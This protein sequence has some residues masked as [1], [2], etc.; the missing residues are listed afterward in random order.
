VSLFNIDPSNPTNLTLAGNP[1]DSLGDY[2]ISVALL[3]PNSAISQASLLCV[4]NTGARSNLVCFT[5]KSGEVVGHDIVLNLQLDTATPPVS[6]DYTASNVFFAGTYELLTVFRGSPKANSIG[7]IARCLVGGITQCSLTSI[8]GSS[9]PSGGA[10]APSTD[11]FYPK[12]VITDPSFGAFSWAI[13]PANMTNAT[14]SKPTAFYNTIG[15]EGTQWITHST[16]TEEFYMTSS[17]DNLAKINSYGMVESMFIAGG[18]LT[19]LAAAGDWVF[20]LDTSRNICSVNITDG[21]SKFYGN[22]SLPV[23]SQGLAVYSI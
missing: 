12:V 20:I 10:S 7:S 15:Y 1:I 9:N 21:S 5:L 11:S 8:L 4:V 22:G 13:P 6:S 23:G 18:R 2:P 19:E 16:S 3:G 17:N 14:Y